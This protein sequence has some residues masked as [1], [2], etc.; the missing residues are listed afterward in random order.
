MA[1]EKPWYESMITGLGEVASEVASIKV[2][3]YLAQQR[4]E[5]GLSALPDSADQLPPAVDANGGNLTGAVNFLQSE[6]VKNWLMIGGAVVLIV[7]IINN[8]VRN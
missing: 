3:G 8:M 4:Q 6:S 2:T 1:T 5:A 7:I